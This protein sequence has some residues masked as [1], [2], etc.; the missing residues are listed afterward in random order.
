MRNKEEFR[1][2]VISHEKEIVQIVYWD[3]KGK[4]SNLLMEEAE[5]WK[6]AF[7]NF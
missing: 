6:V 2:V 7:E 4:K 3:S 1:N 5:A